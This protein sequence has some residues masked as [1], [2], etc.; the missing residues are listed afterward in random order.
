MKKKRIYSVRRFS[1][2]EFGIIGDATGGGMKSR[3]EEK[4]E[5]S[6]KISPVGT[7]MATAGSALFLGG[8]AMGMANSP[9]LNK[10]GGVM[11]KAGIGLAAAGTAK[12]L[13]DKFKNKE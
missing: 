6:K 4:Q 11:N 12:Y 2:K 5:E 10:F 13:Y 7:G 1:Q 3:M 8:Q 9:T